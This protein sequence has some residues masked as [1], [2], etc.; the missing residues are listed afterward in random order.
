MTDSNPTTTRA[1]FLEYLAEIS[2][3][4][5]EQLRPGMALALATALATK[6]PINGEDPVEQSRWLARKYYLLKKFIAAPSIDAARAY[7]DWVHHGRTV[8]TDDEVL[9]QATAAAVTR[10]V[11][12]VRRDPVLAPAPTVEL[13]P[14]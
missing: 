5:Y 8:S 1:R 10:T 14:R 2:D 12:R 11:R 4:T 13:P 3:E 9:A 6:R 7:D